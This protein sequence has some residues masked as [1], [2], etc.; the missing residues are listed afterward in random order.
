MKNK[1]KTKTQKEPWYLGGGP[2]ELSGVCKGCGL[3]GGRHEI[4]CPRWVSPARRRYL[5]QMEREKRERGN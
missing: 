1:T 2:V 5:E 4:G 3:S